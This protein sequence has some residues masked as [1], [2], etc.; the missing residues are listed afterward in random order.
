[1]A[2]FLITGAT[3]H[4]GLNIVYQL[5]RSNHDIHAF[6]LPNDPLKYKLPSTVKITEGNITKKSHLHYFFNIDN[7]NKATIIHC[8]GIVSTYSR[9][10]ALTYEVNVIGTQNIIDLC[11]QYRVRKLIYIS[12]VHALKVLK[13]GLMMTEKDL[14]IPKMIVGYYGKSKAEATLRV[15]KAVKDHRLNAVVV[16]P[17]G[18]VGGHDY[19]LGHMTHL[20]QNI[21][22]KKMNI[23]MRGGFDF[24]D[25]KDV[26]KGI[27]QCGQT[28]ISGEGYILSNRYVS[29]KEMFTLIDQKMNHQRCRP[30]IPLWIIWMVLP[31]V[32]L[33]DKLLK[34]KPL[35]TPY[36]LYTIH[37]NASFS[38]QKA[39][40]TFGY[41]TRDFKKTIDDTVQWLINEGH[42]VMNQSSNQINK[43]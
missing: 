25:V 3:G 10:D 21:C 9:Y 28:S 4:L 2:L 5:S 17:S 32:N 19:A 40:E 33:V 43:R 27:M 14:V 24:V 39:M 23:W 8:A 11:I 36:A 13:K 1:M 31:C 22:Q 34:R 20:I 30:F 41:Q 15:L 38:K 42:V 37:S 18:I 29:F 35:L 16:Y 6:V 7:I 26:A 12:S